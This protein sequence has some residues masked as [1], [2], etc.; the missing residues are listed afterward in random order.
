MALLRAYVT[1][2]YW[3]EYSFLVIR[4]RGEDLDYEST[5]LLAEQATVGQPGGTIAT[6]GAGWLWA[7]ASSMD[8]ENEVRL[9]AH[10]SAPPGDPYALAGW[11]DVVETPYLSLSGTVG[12]SWLTAADEDQHT[13]RLGPEGHYRVRVCCRRQPAQDTRD[14]RDTAGEEDAEESPAGDVWC[15]QFWPTPAGPEPPRWL[16]RAPVVIDESPDW[17]GDMLDPHVAS[18]LRSALDLAAKHPEGVSAAQITA[19]RAAIESAYAD[20]AD[21]ASPLWPSAPRPFLTTGHP[22]LDAFEAQAHAAAVAE[23]AQRQRDVAELAA[24]TGVPAPVTLGDVLPL[25]VRMGLLSVREDGAQPRYGLPD[26]SGTKMTQPEP[27]NAPGEA[28]DD[29]YYGNADEVADM[30]SVA[31]WTRAGEVGTAADLAER[32]LMPVEDVRAGLRYAQREQWLRVAGDPGDADSRL[33]ITPLPRPE[34]PAGEP[35]PLPLYGESLEVTPVIQEDSGLQPFTIGGEL[36]RLSVRV[37]VTN[38]FSRT[39][40]PL[41]PVGAPPRAGIV[42]SSRNLIVWRDGRAEVLASVPSQAF[43]A[44]ETPPGV[45]VLSCEESVLVRADGQVEALATDADNQAAISA[46]GRYLAISQTKFGRHPKFALHVIDLSDGSRQTLPWPANVV[47]TGMYGGTVFFGAADAG[48]LRWTPGRDPEPLPWE[49]RTV[50][51]LSGRMLVDGFDEDI[52][53]WLVID[54]NG[55]RHNV[56]ASG[57]AELALGGTQMVYLRYE[58]PAVTLFDVATGGATPRVV[59]L[60][61]GSDTGTGGWAW[62]DAGHLLFSR[63]FAR[64]AGRAARLD[65]RTGEVERVPFPGAQDEELGVFVES[66]AGLG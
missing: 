33:T 54:Q 40:P 50:D 30:I 34:Q 20:Q 65:V 18:V 14:V 22:D 58:P 52:D 7:R 27:A 37:A 19:D 15:L 26:P 64:D 44:I 59:W 21:P 16:A 11:D 48:S 60:P 3:A 51:R 17:G 62:E 36:P 61:E 8:A 23:W 5:G 41:P 28:E 55:E 57:A 39:G 56:L 63:R 25:L 31:L 66:L 1:D 13:L 46:D 45:V 49:P 42:T 53:G 9:E 47:V 12:L 29:D 38:A 6:A 4:D 43:R 35:R 10:D 32:L 2:E 24:R